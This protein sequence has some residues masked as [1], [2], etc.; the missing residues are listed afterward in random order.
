MSWRPGE[1]LYCK[2]NFPE[3]SFWRDF[4]VFEELA[5]KRKVRTVDSLSRRESGVIFGPGPEAK[6]H[7]RKVINPVGASQSNSEGRFQRTMETFYHPVAL[8]MVTSPLDVGDSKDGA[9]LRPN[10][11][12]ELSSSVGG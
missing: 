8:R 6:H 10:S 7:Q 1:T 4:A 3:K 9:D 2:I 5:W 12:R 11:R